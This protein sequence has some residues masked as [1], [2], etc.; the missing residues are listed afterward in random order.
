MVDKCTD[1]QVHTYTCM[2]AYTLTNRQKLVHI[3]SNTY[4][5][6]CAHDISLYILWMIECSIIYIVDLPQD[7]SDKGLVSFSYCLHAYI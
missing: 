3:Y 1:M 5:H 7:I 2:H 4:M 6:A